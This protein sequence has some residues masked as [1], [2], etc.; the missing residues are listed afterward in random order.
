[1]QG[2]L[3]AASSAPA[4]LIMHQDKL[5][6]DPDL[7]FQKGWRKFAACSGNRVARLL[8]QEITRDD[9]PSIS[10]FFA[11]SSFSSSDELL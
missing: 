5:L 11:S 7:L 4:A 3:R 8:F 1:M 6:L 2:V 9:F 10:I